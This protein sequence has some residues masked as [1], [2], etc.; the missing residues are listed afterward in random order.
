MHGFAREKVMRY[1]EI[2]ET[3]GI[4]ASNEQ[5]AM[6]ATRYELAACEVRTGRVLEVACGTGIGL[7]FLARGARFVVGCDIDATNLGMAQATYQGQERIYLERADACALPHG[8]ASFDMITCFEGVYYF[9]D[10]R[11]FLG[12]CRRIL[13]PAGRLVL[14]S[15]N[16]NWSG[17]IRSPYSTRYWNPK[18]LANELADAGFDYQMWCA[19]PDVATDLVAKAVRVIRKGAVRLHLIPR[20]MRGKVLLKKV[21]YRRVTA[22]PARFVPS[23]AQGA[24]LRVLNPRSEQ[25]PFKVFYAVATP[26]G[27]PHSP[28]M[29]RHP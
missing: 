26:V 19:F 14:C 16:P 18:E 4:G 15:V 27:G 28:V 3:P 8:P 25:F 21:F 2:T 10:L 24:R 22:M 29:A 23:L 13:T 7:G 5:L 20:T 17:F 6:L 12:E 1:S 9:S 11:R